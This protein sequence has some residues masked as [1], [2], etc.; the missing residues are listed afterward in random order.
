MSFNHPPKHEFNKYEEIALME[1]VKALDLILDLERSEVDT[2]DAYYSYYAQY[3]KNGSVI[4]VLL[5]EHTSTGDP[6]QMDVMY[7]T[8]MDPGDVATK[9]VPRVG[10]NLIL[11]RLIG[12]K[13]DNTITINF[14]DHGVSPIDGITGITIIGPDGPPPNRA[15]ISINSDV[16]HSRL[17]AKNRYGQLM[18]LLGSLTIE[19]KI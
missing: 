9:T 2:F 11:N 10:Y 3:A 7:V 5:Q 18:A 15:G 1:Q 4:D 13:N 6:Y 12:S 19:D 16:T 14:E 17:F 8:V